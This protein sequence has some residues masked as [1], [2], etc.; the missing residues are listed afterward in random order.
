MR[1]GA[2]GE[3]ASVEGIEGGQS[4]SLTTF[5]ECRHVNSLTEGHEKETKYNF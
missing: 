2:K 1:K 3:H 4:D 5:T